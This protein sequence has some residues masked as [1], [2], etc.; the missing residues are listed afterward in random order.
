MHGINHRTHIDAFVQRITNTQ[1][2]H[3]PLEFVIESVRDTFLH[4]QA[5]S[6]AADL[7]LVEPDRVDEPFDCAIQ[8]GVIKNDVGGF[9]TQLQGERLAGSGCRL[10]DFATHFRRSGKGNLI[11]VWVS[12]DHFTNRSVTRHDIHDALWQSGLAADIGKKQR[13][14]RR[15]LGWFQNNRVSHRDR[16]RDL[17][18]QHQQREVPRNDLTAHAQGLAVRK[19]FIH[20]LR[21]ARVVIEMALRQRDI[22]ITR[23]ADRLAVIQRFQ[24]RKKPGVF[25]QQPRDGV[26]VTRPRCA[27][28]FLPL[29]L[30]LSSGCHRGVHIGRRC[31]R[32]ACQYLT[33]R[34][35]TAFEFVGRLGECPVDEL[36]KP[37]TLIYQPRK[38]FG[39]TFG[40]GAVIHRFEDLFN[41]HVFFSF[42]MR[43][44]PT[45]CLA[46]WMPVAGR[47]PACH[48]M[49]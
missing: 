29:A 25:L 16:R 1:P 6:S 9:P 33:S 28:D 2:V 3:A 18:C 22:D 7:T 24:H 44:R 27:T 45:G 47:I 26:D 35:V 14:E 37:V 17:P 19:L 38:C 48:V 42:Q 11:D 34:R 15:V 20:Q 40:G 5:R 36:P 30:R 8:I 21:H 13:C 23:L 32:E 41:S 46:D 49:L 43:K 4:Q 39:S 12:N 31:L 10:P